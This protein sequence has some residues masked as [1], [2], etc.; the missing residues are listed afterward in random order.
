MRTQTHAQRL[1]AAQATYWA[2]R[3]RKKPRRKLAWHEHKGVAYYD[4]ERM[5]QS[6]LRI[7]H[8]CDFDGWSTPLPSWIAADW[9]APEESC[10]RVSS[11]DDSP[12][13]QTADYTLDRCH[14]E[15]VC[16]GE[17]VL[18]RWELTF[19][20]GSRFRFVSRA[21]AEAALSELIRIRKATHPRPK[22]AKHSSEK[23][24]VFFTD[25]RLRT[26]QADAA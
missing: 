22:F 2:L 10:Q 8:P 12:L 3:D 4:R 1:A 5:R 14:V 21:I 24:G 7:I 11:L 13:A 23:Q 25:R 20:D 19:A 16:K 15:T 9:A 18:Y 26:L 6:L 17:Q